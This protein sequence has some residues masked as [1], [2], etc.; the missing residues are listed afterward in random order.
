MSAHR[1]MALLPFSLLLA[2][3]A[4]SNQVSS[5]Q[6]STE[7]AQF[8]PAAA[9]QTS[10]FADGYAALKNGDND[11][12]R[13]KF[14]VSYA[15]APSDPYESLDLGAAYQNGGLI[16]RA[17]PLY[18]KTIKQGSGVYPADVTQPEV[19]GLPL[20][21]IA[22]H[23]MAIA[24]LDEYGRPL[25][26]IS[27][28]SEEFSAAV[29]QWP[30]TYQIFFDF[31]KS[32]L[33]PSARAIIHRAAEHVK[34]GNSVRITVIGHTD[35]VGSATY[36]MGLSDRRAEAAASEMIADGVPGAEIETHGVGKS[37]LL[38]PTADGIREPRNRRV[39]ILEVLVP[40]S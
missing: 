26:G 38:V 21:E 29:A 6:T 34:N 18:R 11:A 28:S 17:L 9:N 30:M 3:C 33:S 39:E 7:Q 8:T 23:N 24:G 12:A 20:D 13:Q 2:A 40:T 10:A 5:T 16:E 1:I 25:R 19:E 35:T 31:D 22:K 14:E 36:N 27:A 15:T 37:D 4:S 32:N